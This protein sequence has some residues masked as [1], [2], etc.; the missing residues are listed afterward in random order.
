MGATRELQQPLLL[1][2]DCL[3]NSGLRVRIGILN[4]GKRTL[5]RVAS[6][7]KGNG[8]FSHLLALRFYRPVSYL[9]TWYQGWPGDTSLVPV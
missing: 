1:T 6:Y 3:D 5:I 2:G 7:L 8:S 9:S 4:G